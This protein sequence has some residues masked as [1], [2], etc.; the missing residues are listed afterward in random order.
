ML[1]AFAA[2]LTIDPDVPCE[3]EGFVKP[4]AVILPE[5]GVDTSLQRKEAQ[6][7][8]GEAVHRP[9]LR[10]FQ[11]AQRRLGACRDVVCCEAIMRAQLVHGNGSAIG[12]LNA[13]R[14][15]ALEGG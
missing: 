9:D 8:G 4:E 7:M 5:G 10:F 14:R 11:I 3:L 13:P 1:G 15:R 12:R 6:Q 2:E